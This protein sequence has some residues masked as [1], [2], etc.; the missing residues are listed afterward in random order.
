MYVKFRQTGYIGGIWDQRIIGRINSDARQCKS[1]LV[2]ESPSKYPPYLERMHTMDL[3]LQ[4]ATIVLNLVVLLSGIAFSV[5]KFARMFG[6]LEN[7]IDN[8]CTTLKMQTQDTDK[9][10]N[11]LTD[12]VK[13]IDKRV[14][15]LETKSDA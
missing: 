9:K 10:I 5:I 7:K 1:I 12:E 6:T 13:S 11:K 8:V 4:I 14:T 3:G 15:V 2:P